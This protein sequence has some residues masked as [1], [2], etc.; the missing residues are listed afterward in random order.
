MCSG[1]SAIHLERPGSTFF[2]LRSPSALRLLS[3]SR[4]R[5]S[6]EV[7]AFGGFGFPPRADCFAASSSGAQFRLLFF[8]LGQMLL[9]TS[10]SFNLLVLV[11]LP[12]LQFSNVSSMSRGVYLPPRVVDF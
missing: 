6:S 12:T 3:V 11:N 10:Q 7:A 4:L 1:A 8:N 2:E 9:L 5:T